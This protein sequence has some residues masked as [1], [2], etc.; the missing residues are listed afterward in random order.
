MTLADVR[1]YIALLGIAEDEH[2]YCGKMPD[3]KEKSVGVYP[4][5][6]ERP[7]R[8]PLGGMENASYGTK[9]VSILV[10][11]NKTPEEAEKAAKALQEALT[12]CREEKVNEWNI[13]FI[14]LSHA[15]PIPVGTD[16]DGIYEYV[17]EGMVY[18]EKVD[19]GE[20]EGV[21]K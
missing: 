14:I 13:K 8:I 15:E 6:R 17:L 16:D 2:C 18:Y 12:G 1:D 10:H 3:K 5:K 19:S 4:Y 21:K 7:M 9:A 20:K 11:W